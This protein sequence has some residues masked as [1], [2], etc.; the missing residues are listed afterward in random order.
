MMGAIS[1]DAS[2]STGFFEK[3]GPSRR[4]IGNLPQAFTHLALVSA[5]TYLDEA[6]DTR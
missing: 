4:M 3:I 5:A 6:L 2:S 1:S